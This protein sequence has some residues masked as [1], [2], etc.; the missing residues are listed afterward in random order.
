MKK[1]EIFKKLSE[2]KNTLWKSEKERIKDN[3][4]LPMIVGVLF[5]IIVGILSYDNSK[6][7]KDNINSIVLSFFTGSLGAFVCFAYLEWKRSVIGRE[8]ELKFIEESSTRILLEFEKIKP[9]SPIITQHRGTSGKYIDIL[10]EIF[11]KSIEDCGGIIVSAGPREYLGYLSQFLQISN[12]TF[13]ATLR[14]GETKP[15]F[16]LKWF[17]EDDDLQDPH[18]LSKNDKKKYL[19]DVNSSSTREKKRILFFDKNEEE[20]KEDFKNQLRRNGFFDLNSNVEIY[21]ASPKV[22]ISHLQ[23]KGIPESKANFI[24][25]DYA[26]FDNEVVLKH[27]STTSLYVATKDQIKSFKAV[28]ELLDNEV[29][30][31]EKLTKTHIGKQTW[32]E[33]EA[34]VEKTT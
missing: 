3:F 16:R 34:N 28:F 5:A 13:C 18:G 27:N 2:Y 20:F 7:L 29:Y 22:I 24:Y 11:K 9:C 17:F 32:D 10:L 33:W 12:E 6:G 8:S 19:E 30:I 4:I 25:E 14:G 26:I 21:L 1:L 15:R 23:N 31:F